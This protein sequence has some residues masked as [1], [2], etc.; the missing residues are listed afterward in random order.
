MI[1]QWAI[2]HQK[3]WT[4]LKGHDGRNDVT[5]SSASSKHGEIASIFKDAEKPFDNS[6]PFSYDPYFRTIFENLK[7]AG[8]SVHLYAVPATN[9]LFRYRRVKQLSSFKH[10]WL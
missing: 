2:D 7:A 8:N 5:H 1:F 10:D 9:L 4:Q 6:L 3:L